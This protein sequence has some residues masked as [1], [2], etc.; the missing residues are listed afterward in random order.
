MNLD[1]LSPQ[2]IKNL[3]TTQLVALAQ[4]IRDFLVERLSMTGGHLSSNLGIVELT[5]ALHYCFDSPKD[6]FLWDVGH[7]AYVHKIVTGRGY[8]FG[9]LRK[10]QGLSGFPSPRESVHDHFSTGH[11]STALSSALGLATGRDLTGQNH[12]VVA[13]IGDGS[14]TGGLVFEALNNLGASGTD[15]LAV[16]NDNELSIS[17]NVGALHRSDATKADFFKAM[18]MTYVGPINGHDIESLIQTLNELKGRKG[19]ILLHVK[20]QKGKGYH[21]AEAS[22]IQ[23]HGVGRFNQETHLTRGDEPLTYSEL[24]GETLTKMAQTHDKLVAVTAAMPTGTGLD[25]F[26][27]THPT[28]FFDVGISEPH[29]LIFATGLAK[30]GLVPVVAM[31]S[32]FLQRGYDQLIHDVCLS[33]QHVV[34]CLDRAGFVGED[35]ETH[36]G[37][38]DISYL[39]HIPNMTLMAPK[40]KAEYLAMLDYAVTQ[41]RGPIAIRY[42]KAIPWEGLGCAPIAL[43][44]SE[45]LLKGTKIALVAYGAITQT[46]Y[47][48]AQ[49]LIAAGYDP[50]CINAR[51]AMPLDLQMLQDLAEYQ[52]IFTFEE[53]MRMGGFGTLV[54]EHVSVTH[55]FAVDRS[56]IQTASRAEL[57]ANHGLDQGGILKEIRA[58]IQD[59]SQR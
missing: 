22:P 50:T 21:F 25:V 41:H 18:G 23:Y 31:Y 19:P 34:F 54:A 56:Y 40:N 2:E 42:P 39:S 5:L 7:Q 52:Y 59:L 44:K 6:K 14:L 9:G 8:L 48:V 43:G 3:E 36:Q 16:L 57:L 38:F 4:Q 15:M 35:G 29:G 55:K 28:R 45:Y 11:A 51:F 27:A 32:T 33:N 13:V 1:N 12:Q 26:K 37:L 46:V 17:E 53:N 47:E 49:A 10:Y 58:K 24:L 30:T 20:T